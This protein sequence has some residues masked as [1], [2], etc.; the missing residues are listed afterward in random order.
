MTS[1]G[2]LQKQ[3]VVL[4]LLS[5]DVKHAQRLHFL[6]KSGVHFQLP[7]Q[8]DL[9]AGPETTEMKQKLRS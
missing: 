5:A 2:N 3:G 7:L 1:L 6:R 4:S 8:V 9:G